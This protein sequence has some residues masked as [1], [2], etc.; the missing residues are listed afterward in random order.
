MAVKDPTGG[1][2]VGHESLVIIIKIS[3]LARSNLE[4][5]QLAASSKSG[6]DQNKWTHWLPLY[7]ENISANVYQCA[8]F[9]IKNTQY[10]WKPRLD[11]HR[12]CIKIIESFLWKAMKTSNRIDTLVCR[13]NSLVLYGNMQPIV[14]CTVGVGE[15]LFIYIYYCLL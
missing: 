15:L 12:W 1:F 3:F 5:P 2:Y 4:T 9:T 14:A 7:G 6:L 13:K 10:E 11:I 8:P